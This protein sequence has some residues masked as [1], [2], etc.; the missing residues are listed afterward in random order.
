[1]IKGISKRSVTFL[2]AVVFSVALVPMLPAMAEAEIKIG[3]YVQI[4]TYYG[5]PILWR[6]VDIDEN[7][8]LMLSDKIICLK[9]FDA[10]ASANSSPNSHSRN[11]YRFSYGS[12]Y[13][14]DS[15]MRSWLNSD[16]GAGNVNWLCGN[17]PV[18]SQVLDGHND[19]ADEAGFLTN[20]TQAELNAVKV[21]TQKSFVAYP[22]YENEIYTM[23]TAG[24]DYDY[25][26]NEIVQNYDTAYAEYVTDKIFLLDVKQ[27][28][29]V[30]N[31]SN[32]L[33]E[34]YYIGKP[35]AQCVA[36]SEY[37]NS[38]FT[39]ENKC[40]Y[41]LRSPRTTDDG[42]V[43]CVFSDGSVYNI[44]AYYG[45]QGVRPAFYLN[46]SSFTAT[47]GSGTESNPYAFYKNS[48]VNLPTIGKYSDSITAKATSVDGVL[49]V[50]LDMIDAEVTEQ[51]VT[52]YAA[53]YD[54]NL[55]TSVIILTPSISEEKIVYSGNVTSNNYRI[56]VWDKDLVPVTYSYENN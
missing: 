12:N 56:F 2:L 6:C 11:S 16:A 7:G 25:N 36:N 38:S 15:N 19:Y 23:G 52:V 41:W 45:N 17:P 22:E 40:N 20:F 4:G 18:E 33:G 46:L 29:A 9:S 1:M 34:D 8:P 26:I 50:E 5:E 53:Q 39:T 30:Y 21:V 24:H 37:T 31:N 47:F 32:I 13:W 55:L 3:D 43:R 10:G 49:E 51:D 42:H 35:T 27:I 48:S 44:N 54:D 14:A 28:N